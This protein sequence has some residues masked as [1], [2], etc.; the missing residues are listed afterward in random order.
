MVTTALEEVLFS[1]G[2]PL[3]IPEWA[4]SDKPDGRFPPVIA[5]VRLPAA[6]AASCV[7]YGCPATAL[8]S[9]VV[10]IE[11]MIDV[12]TTCSVT[13]TVTTEIVGSPG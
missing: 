4:S 5:H 2:V 3:M 13:G 7:E 9:E 1:P 11:R 6:D 8:G 12:G 10:V